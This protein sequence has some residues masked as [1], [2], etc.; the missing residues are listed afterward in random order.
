MQGNGQASSPS[1]GARPGSAPRTGPRVVQ[2]SSDTYGRLGA[3]G[4]PCIRAEA[5]C[6]VWPLAALSCACLVRLRFVGLKDYP[7]KMISSAEEITLRASDQIVA[8][9]PS[10]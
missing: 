5:V 9:E 10:L 1:Y 3:T 7:T 2:G 4:S 6:W 8:I